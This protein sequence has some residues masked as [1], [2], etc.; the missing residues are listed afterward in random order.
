MTLKNSKVFITRKLPNIIEKRMNELFDVQF[1]ENEKPINKS[2]LIERCEDVSVL[3]PTLGDILDEEFFNKIGNNLKLIANYGAGYDNINVKEAQKKKI[4]VSNTPDV[5]TNDTADVTIALILSITR[6][7]P[8]GIKKVKEN[9][10]LGWSPTEIMGNRI[11]GKKLGILGMG[12]IGQAVAKKALCFDLKINYHN[13]NKLHILTERELKATFWTNLNHML[14]EIDIL[15]IHIPHTPSTFHLLNNTRLK[16]LKKN[17]FVINTARGEVIDETSLTRMLQ[18]GEISGA[19]LD[20]HENGH[21]INP[22]LKELEN[23]ILLPH[24]SS[25]TEESRVEMGEKVIM[26]IKAFIDGHSPPDKIIP[27]NL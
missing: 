19:G 20:V 8:Q 1:S 22:R 18:L 21:N 4:I 3:V 27:N 17:A 10:W 6:N 15:S 25:S 23:V 26:N 9:K 11:A 5:L 16:L 2:L 13:R 14:R 7:L 24:M 12:R